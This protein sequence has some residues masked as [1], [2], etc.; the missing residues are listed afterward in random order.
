VTSLKAPQVLED[1]PPE[2][3]VEEPLEW[4]ERPPR[5][6]ETRCEPTAER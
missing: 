1:D 6:E 3:W 2:D 5:I 4:I